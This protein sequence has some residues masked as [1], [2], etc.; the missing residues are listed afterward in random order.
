MRSP[1]LAGLNQVA[2]VFQCVGN[3]SVQAIGPMVHGLKGVRPT[4]G[5]A[6][7]L[8]HAG[9]DHGACIAFGLGMRPKGRHHQIAQAFKGDVWTGVEGNTQQIDSGPN[10]WVGGQRTPQADV[11]YAWVF[12]VYCA[13]GRRGENLME[14]V[15]DAK[16]QSIQIRNHPAQASLGVCF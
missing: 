12:V 5:V 2:K 3:R 15:L 11:V 10:Q 9:V 14:R 4:H 1:R 13:H 8:P 6:S 16:A 7:A